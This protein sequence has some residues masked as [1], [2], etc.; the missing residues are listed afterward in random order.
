MSR[1]R[2]LW[3]V[4]A[5]VGSVALLSAC[6]ANS[7]GLG[8]PANGSSGQAVEADAGMEH[9]HNLMLADGG[10]LIGTH[11][12]LWMQRGAS[13]VARIGKSHFDVMGLARTPNGLVASGHPGAGEEQVNDL[14]LRG[15]SDQ[16]KTWNNI[17]LFGKVDFHR[18]VASGTT[19]LGISAHEGALLRSDDSGKT[20]QTLPDPSLYDLAMDPTDPSTIVGTTQNGPVRSLDGGKSFTSIPGSPLLALLSWDDTRL[21]GVTAAGVLFESTDKGAAWRKIA[22]V[23]GEPSALTVRGSEMALLT[24]STVYYSKDGGISFEP[25]I[26]GVM[27]H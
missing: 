26:V 24:D 19:V 18:L 7:I 11:E 4:V 5:G 13:P 14:G 1:M 6:S 16:G 21:V 3:W 10:L 27:G 23:K 15:S 22:T 2:R 25:R 8:A 17:S 20:W 9:I 12:G